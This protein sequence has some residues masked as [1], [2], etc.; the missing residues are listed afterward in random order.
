MAFFRQARGFERA[1][2]LSP[3]K[4]GMPVARARTLSLLRAWK[5]IAGES[6][7]QQVRAVEIK[8][9]VLELEAADPA[10]RAAVEPLLPAL[11]GRLVGEYPKLGAVKYRVGLAGQARPASTVAIELP[12][13]VENLPRNKPRPLPAR[14]VDTGDEPQVDE[15]RLRR[16]SDRYLERRVEA[17]GQVTPERTEPV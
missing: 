4:M 17:N 7:A 11:T 8:R 14:A 10:W 15:H 3:A 5:L 16:L 1:G 2:N 9:G 12:A 6:L 13:A